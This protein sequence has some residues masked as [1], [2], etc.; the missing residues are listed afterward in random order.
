MVVATGETGLGIG[1]TTETETED[2][3]VVAIG[4]DVGVASAV[5]GPATEDEGA[6]PGEPPE[7]SLPPLAVG[8]PGP[9]TPRTF[10]MQR[11]DS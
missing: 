4:D 7:A 1:A 11:V 8:V 10:D 2:D 9:T 3:V 6:E 5:E